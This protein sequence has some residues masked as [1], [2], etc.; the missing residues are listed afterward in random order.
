[1]GNYDIRRRGIPVWQSTL[2]AMKSAGTRVR[3]ICTTPCQFWTEV[4]VDD[5]IGELR[6]ADMTLWDARPPCPIC[7]GL[8]RFVASPGQGTPF[9]PLVSDPGDSDRRPLPPQAWMAGWT[10]R[11]LP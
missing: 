2:G 11:R 1:M 8:A 7:D 4:D 5:M 6:G 9:R 10:G 3:L